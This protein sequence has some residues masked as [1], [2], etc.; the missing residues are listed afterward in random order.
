MVTIDGKPFAKLT[1]DGRL[2]AGTATTVRLTKDGTVLV[3]G[4]VSNV[5][6]GTEATF[7]LDGATALTI[8]SAGAITGPLLADI[9]HSMFEAAG[10]TL[11]YAGPPEARRAIMFAFAAALT[12]A[13]AQPVPAKP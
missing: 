13:P 10:A 2:Q 7:T 1:R 12:S 4:N 5:H 11:T 6:V 8:D 9:D 3:H